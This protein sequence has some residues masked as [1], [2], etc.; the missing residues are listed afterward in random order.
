[1]SG[2]DDART[3]Q[4]GNRRWQQLEALFDEGTA[5]PRGQRAGWLAALPVEP[6]VRDEL[7]R[8]LA[9]D[10]GGHTLR[11]RVDAVVATAS[12]APSMGE[13]IG[14]WRLLEQIGAGGMGA[15][16]LVERVDGGFAQQAALKLVRGV[17][18]Q[19]SIRQLRHERQVLAALE[20]PGIARLLDG[21]ET[22]Q[23]QPY[24][25]MEYV[26]GDPI[27]VAARRRNLGLRDRLR[28]LREVALAVHHAHRQLV[29]HRDIKPGN[30]LLRED[31]R[32]VL[33][34]FGIAKLLDA[35]AQAQQTGTAPYFTPAY[36]SPEQRRGQPVSTATDIYALGL[37]LAEL[38]TCRPAVLDPSGR[39]RAPSEQMPRAGRGAVRG[40]IDRIVL[41]ACAEEPERR[42]E[43]AAALAN[44][45][46]RHLAG[47]P[48]RAAPDSGWYVFGKFLRRHPAG[49]A[50]AL[51]TA[52][53]LAVSAWQV[54]A[55]RN[56]A[57]LAEQRAEQEARSAQAVT[58]YLV[59]LFRE[60][61]PGS[62]RGRSLRPAE[63]IDR[64]VARLAAE[65]ALEPAARAHL[66]GALGSIYNLLGL[67]QKGSQTLEDAVRHARDSGVDGV[68]ADALSSLGAALEERGQFDR[69]EQV[70]TEAQALYLQQQDRVQA[71]NAQAGI[72][73]VQ[74]RMGRFAEAEATLHEAHAA[75]VAAQGRDSL[76]ALR[77]AA[78]RSEVLRDSGRA[79]EARA[80]LE[81]LLSVMQARLPEDH[82][83]LLEAYGYYANTL[84]L[85]D[86]TARAQEVFERMLVHRQRLLEQDRSPLGF[87]HNG[88]GTLYYQQGRT[89]E[90]AEQMTL[91]LAIGER[92]LGPDD[93]SLALDINNVG[94][95]YEEM[96]DYV[97]A[98]PLLRRAYAIMERAQADRPAQ[99]AQFRQ[100]LGRLLMLAGK[101]D[102]A[103]PLI[104]AP[105]A[106]EPGDPWAM[107][108]ARR[109][110]HRAE[111]QRRYGDPGQAAVLLDEAAPLI[112][113]VSG[114]NSAR[115]AALLRSR[116][117]LSMAIGSTADARQQLQE[118]RALLAAARGERY[119]GVAEIDLDLAELDLRNAD[120]EA[121][122]AR[123]YAAAPIID[124]VAAVTAP[125]RSRLAEL[126][127]AAG[128]RR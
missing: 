44:D 104:E 32:P 115:Y 14:P 59:G 62:G 106:D 33:L 37:L 65:P 76:D 28:L 56:R 51:F 47:L 73:L 41:R 118:A 49:V 113:A 12:V 82:P 128:P 29:I 55:D 92:T 50:L 83:R 69:A 107:Q 125:Q 120:R 101:A 48:V 17:A 114:R 31:G 66:L 72:G 91:A 60:A 122:R 86:D 25:V 6:G 30:V 80:E 85:L 1:M 45:I 111:W 13:R 119:I 68:L 103:F 87:V 57:L 98:E 19:Q 38:V 112:D 5:L 22:V 20:H 7:S 42:Y 39:L 52:G 127:G 71:A 40:D 90:A 58:A 67:P 124:E 89:R 74:S 8:L 11:D 99:F 53:V 116:G 110:F 94:S 126:Q 46:E 123:L 84:L 35:D 79:P 3:L 121:A 96:G 21:G 78:F 26:R 63:L 81:R 34:D 102:E 61:D 100:N 93:S 97:R 43:S 27:T 15:V 75:L 95:L 10:S 54:V 18:T 105:I 70:L 117:L 4:P 36:A 2:G 16:F 77:V 23:G 24:L 108:R 64:G 88:L 9:A 109:A